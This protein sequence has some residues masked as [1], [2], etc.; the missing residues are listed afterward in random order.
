MLEFIREITGILCAAFVTSFGLGRIYYSPAVLGT[1][2]K[3][4][5]NRQPAKDQRNGLRIRAFLV[6]VFTA[7]V[8]SKVLGVAPT[9]WSAL[10][11]G[12][13]CGILGACAIAHNYLFTN[14]DPRLAV[15]DGA[16]QVLSCGVMGA[17]LSYFHSPELMAHK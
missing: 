10:F 12:L 8:L 14:V 15:V 7:L 3:N 4:H 16:Y 13:V 1:Y 2:W 11:R 5:S 9:I 17:V 6:N